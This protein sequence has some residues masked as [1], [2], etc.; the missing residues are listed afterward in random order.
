[1]FVVIVFIYYYSISV[2]RTG[3][4]FSVDSYSLV[5]T[6]HVLSS[7]AWNSISVN[8]FNIV[9]D[10]NGAV[11]VWKLHFCYGLF[12]HHWDSEVLTYAV[13]NQRGP[14]VSQQDFYD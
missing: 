2:G 14:L 11:S 9:W 3:F 5:N 8:N 4:I 1:M 7:S 10:T 6:F 13:S 12:S